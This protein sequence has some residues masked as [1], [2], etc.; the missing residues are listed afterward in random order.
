[1]LI[2]KFTYNNIKNISTSYT[3][4]ELNS[5]FYLFILYKKHID[6]YLMS[7]AINKYFAK[8]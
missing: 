2:A 4:F 3:Y 1:M 5:I 8:V 7:K 6:F